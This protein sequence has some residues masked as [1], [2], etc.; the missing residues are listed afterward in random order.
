MKKIKLTTV[1]ELEK[2][3]SSEIQSIKGG[4]SMVNALAVASAGS[5]HHDSKKKDHFSDNI[6]F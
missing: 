2:M 5:E 6:L 4:V 1:S 3:N